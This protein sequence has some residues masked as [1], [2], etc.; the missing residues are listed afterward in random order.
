MQPGVHSALISRLVSIS[1]REP[2][3]YPR[4]ARISGALDEDG[5]SSFISSLHLRPAAPRRAAPSL[6]VFPGPP[7][8]HALPST[9]GRD[10]SLPS[11]PPPRFLSSSPL[12]FLRA[13]RGFLSI[14]VIRLRLRRRLFSPAPSRSILRRVA[15]SPFS[16]R[17]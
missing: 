14:A 11:C 10:L 16:L 6:F 3:S 9:F 1:P 2:L 15:F 5:T 4:W 17:V 8:S 13:T 7:S 12:P